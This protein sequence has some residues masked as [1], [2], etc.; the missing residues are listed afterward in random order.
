MAQTNGKIYFY[1]QNKGRN[2]HDNDL[3]SVL[4]QIP[5]G[6]TVTDLDGKILY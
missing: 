4:D 5:I 2:M 3:R 6:I 1:D